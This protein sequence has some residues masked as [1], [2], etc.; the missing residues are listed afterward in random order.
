MLGNRLRLWGSLLTRQG[1]SLGQP[2]IVIIEATNVCDKECRICVHKNLTRPKGFMSLDLFRTIIDQIPSSEV[3]FPYFIGEPLLHPG[4]FEMI[5][6][7]KASGHFVSIST[8]GN[9]LSV[10]MCRKLVESGL[11]H[12]QISLNAIST[13]GFTAIDPSA[14]FQAAL[15]NIDRF[16]R[17]NQGRIDFFISVVNMPGNLKE[18]SAFQKIWNKKGVRV[19]FKFYVDWNSG[20]EQI[21]SF[22]VQ[23][24]RRRRDIYPCDWLWRQFHI[25]W[26]GKVVPCCFDPDG[27]H[28]VGDV[29]TARVADIWNGP[30]YQALRRAHL[31]DGAS[32]P[33]C[34][35]CNRRKV[36][37]YEIP[38]QIFFDA[39]WIYKLRMAYEGRPRIYFG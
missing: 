6:Y 39:S 10:D 1:R 21:K 13:E 33:L 14:D 26:D 12:L 8:N 4:L 34:A 9:L 36:P 16:I 32:I 7:M 2:S 29:T 3:T 30:E 27:S 11:D 24:Q 20:D 23:V 15:E 22:G 25:F 37:F 38:A 19:R 17:I 5:N 28:V 31:G 35:Q 18:W